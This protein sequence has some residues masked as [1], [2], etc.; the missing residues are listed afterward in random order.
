MQRPKARK[1]LLEWE[2]L[3]VSFC[4]RAGGTWG[5]GARR[6]FGLAIR[7]E[8]WPTARGPKGLGHHAQCLD[9]TQW[10]AM[11]RLSKQAR[12]VKGCL[13]GQVEPLPKSPS[14]SFLHSLIWARLFPKQYRQHC[15]LNFRVSV[16]I[17]I[18]Q[19]DAS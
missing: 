17:S 10:A 8:K 15:A 9:F 13:E 14:S 7:I 2:R 12:K 4:R 3:V 18:F 6:W 16:L 5:L 19:T 1:A 11:E